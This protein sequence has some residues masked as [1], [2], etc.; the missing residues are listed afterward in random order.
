[1]GAARLTSRPLTWIRLHERGDVKRTAVNTSATLA[2]ATLSLST[3][4]TA[5]EKSPA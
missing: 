1:M 5:G 4:A 3:S 2:G